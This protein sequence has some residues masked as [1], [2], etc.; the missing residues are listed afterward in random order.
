MRG[1]AFKRGANPSS[2]LFPSPL[3]ERGLRGE[4]DSLL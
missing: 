2:I 4:V 1:G 3:K